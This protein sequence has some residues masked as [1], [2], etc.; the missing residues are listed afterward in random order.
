[1]SDHDREVAQAF[2]GQAERFERAPVQSDPAA[3]ARLVEF[4]ALPAGATVLDA[5]CGPGLVSEALLAAGFRVH[6]VDLSAEMVRRAQ[7]RCARFGERARFERGSVL[8]ASL[9]GP[10][11]AA[12]SR[13]VLHHTPDPLAFLRRQVELVRPAGVV[14]ASDHTT[15]PDPA[16]AAWHQG[17]ERARDRSHTRCLTSGEM[18]DLLARA[19]LRSLTLTEESF[20][21]DFDEWFDRGTP[22]RPKA[23]VRRLVLEGRARGFEPE[24]RPDGRIALHAV[25]ARVRGARS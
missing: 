19:G 15:D 1:M 12:I 10:V 6:G 17:I 23:E 18:V 25:H 24:P 11:D 16:A 5:G 4:A 8:D 22:T 2:D 9:T 20:T 3:L 13:L 14:L 21:L 7:V